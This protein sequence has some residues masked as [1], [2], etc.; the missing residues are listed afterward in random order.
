MRAQVA[1][2]RAFMTDISYLLSNRYQRPMSSIVV[3][4][5]HSA[6][7]VFC[8][9]FQGAYVMSVHALPAQLQPTTN[10]RNA[11]L[12]QKHLEDALGVKPSRGLLRFVPTPEENVARNGKTLA[13]EIEEGKLTAGEAAEQFT[14]LPRA[15]SKPQSRLSV[16][17][18][19][20]GT[21]P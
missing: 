7:M 4:L 20:S 10:K 16:R 18:S 1:D 11:A 9:T 13:G 15:R 19:F 12:I 6:S 2:E 3:T 17:V 21:F 5:Q 14:G 8:G